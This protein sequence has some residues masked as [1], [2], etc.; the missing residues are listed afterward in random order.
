MG[1]FLSSS[2]P[3]SPPTGWQFNSTVN[4]INYESA[5][6]I[7]NALIINAHLISFHF[8]ISTYLLNNSNNNNSNNSN[9]NNKWT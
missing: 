2:S 1:L 9:I 3:P 6:M 4:N 8:I 7:V 5:S